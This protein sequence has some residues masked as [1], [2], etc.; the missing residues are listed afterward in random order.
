MVSAT[1][2]GPKRLRRFPGRPARGWV[3]GLVGAFLLCTLA[4]CGGAP[5]SP[6][7]PGEG[8][9]TPAAASAA[10]TSPPAGPGAFAPQLGP[11]REGFWLSWLEPVEGE[12][13][14]PSH[15]F[16]AARRILDDDPGTPE[17]SSPVEIHRGPGFFANWAD[18]PS[19]AEHPDGTLLAH[20]LEK[21]GDATYAYGVRLARST[22]GGTTWQPLGLLH[23]DGSPTEHGF[24]SLWSEEG[25]ASVFRA[26]WLDGRRMQDGGPM[27]LRTARVGAAVTESRVLDGR[28]CDCCPT[29]AVAIPGGALVAYRDRS[30]E[31]VRDVY[32]ARWN[33]ESWGEPRPV[34]RD[35]WVF[36]ACPVNG[37]ALAAHGATTAVAWFTGEGDEPRVRM[38]FTGGKEPAAFSRPVE[39]D[40]QIR[41]DSGGGDHAVLGR[42]ALAL[43][44]PEEAVVAWLGSLHDG[45]AA[46]GK[47]EAG[48]LWLRRVSREGHLGERH[49][50]ARTD[51]GRVSGMPRLTVHGDDLHAVWVE[52][53]GGEPRGLAYARL[54]WESLPAPASSP[55]A[56]EHREPTAGR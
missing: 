54:P 21:T 47:S 40:R 15:R 53:E 28:V 31:E 39:V 27:T 20:W 17:W 35:G 36:P 19:V 33:G 51:P 30:A 22:D 32:A 44:G 45:T 7:E 56:P 3:V 46:G 41:G 9:G 24:V 5:G 43:P 10:Q 25:E 2:A 48:R 29:A 37:P 6:P 55:G 50:L 13:G 1:P 16:V 14:Q 23:D 4:S 38:A 18:V 12:D 26:L 49:V 11:S 34:H 42:V 52:V 8:R